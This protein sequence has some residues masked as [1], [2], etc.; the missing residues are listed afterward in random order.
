MLRGREMRGMELLGQRLIY[1]PGKSK[2]KGVEPYCVRIIKT[3]CIKPSCWCECC[4][5]ITMAF[6]LAFSIIAYC[7]KLKIFVIFGDEM[8]IMSIL[9][10]IHYINNYRT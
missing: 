8:G 5:G 4:F 3:R 10:S 2:K 9:F 1:G 7:V 6:C